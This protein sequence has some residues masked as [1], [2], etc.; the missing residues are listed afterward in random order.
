MERWP[1]HQVSYNNVWHAYEYFH[2]FAADIRLLGW[3]RGDTSRHWRDGGW[4]RS[5][6]SPL[7]RVTWPVWL[8]CDVTSGGHRGWNIRLGHWL[9]ALGSHD[10]SALAHDE[11]NPDIAE[12]H[13]ETWAVVT[14]DGDHDNKRPVVGHSPDAGAG[15]AVKCPVDDEGRNPE[16]K[17]SQPRVLK[18][19]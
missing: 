12:Y 5:T 3:R 18:E 7:G 6:S 2:F 1:S 17:D 16:N 9:N 13:E 4:W 10:G 14:A 15:F 11:K 8:Q 19:D